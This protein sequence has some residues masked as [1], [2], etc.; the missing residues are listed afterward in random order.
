ME[1]NQ[2][3]EQKREAMVQKLLDGPIPAEFHGPLRIAFE[4]CFDAGWI[5][6]AKQIMKNI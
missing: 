3:R 1:P 4:A 5:E 6:C 2:V